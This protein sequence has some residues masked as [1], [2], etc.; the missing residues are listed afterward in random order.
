MTFVLVCPGD[1]H[2]SFCDIKDYIW[3]RSLL[4]LWAGEECKGGYPNGKF[5]RLR[6]GKAGQQRL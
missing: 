1:F 2:R 4:A 3:V 5:G 6:K